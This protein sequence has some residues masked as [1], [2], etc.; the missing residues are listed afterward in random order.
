M[1]LLRRPHPNLDNDKTIRVTLMSEPP[2]SLGI[3]KTPKRPLKGL[4]GPRLNIK[5][6]LNNTKVKVTIA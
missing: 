6:V 2:K 1:T 3:L 5:D 4:T